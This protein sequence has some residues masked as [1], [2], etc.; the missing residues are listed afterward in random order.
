VFAFEILS[1]DSE[2]LEN[3]V[4]GWRGRKE[5]VREC[6]LGFLLLVLGHRLKEETESPSDTCRLAGFCSA[7]LVADKSLHP[8]HLEYEA[9]G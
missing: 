4:V 9:L 7:H 1:H 8:R 3:G 5:S 2:H 6:T